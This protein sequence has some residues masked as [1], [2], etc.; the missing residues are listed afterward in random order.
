[1]I[2]YGSSVFVIGG[3]GDHLMQRYAGLPLENLNVCQSLSADLKQILESSAIVPMR[4]L[5]STRKNHSSIICGNDMAIV[6]GG[7]TFDGKSRDPSTDVFLVTLTSPQ[8]WYHL[9]SLEF[10]RLG[11]TMIE[12]GNRLIVHGGLGKDG[13]CGETFQIEITR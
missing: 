9:G 5:P 2:A 11:H 6:Y 12:V 8:Q 1:M 7:E 4:K 10:G 13:V 3:R